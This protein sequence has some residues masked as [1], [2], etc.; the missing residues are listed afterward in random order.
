MD[1]FDAD[2]YA[3]QQKQN[4]YYPFALKQDWEMGLWL[5]RSGL[6]MAAIDQFLHLQLASYILHRPL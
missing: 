5:L 1:V 6:S 4:L 2:E 3:N